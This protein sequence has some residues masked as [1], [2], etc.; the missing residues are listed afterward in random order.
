MAGDN[1]QEVPVKVYKSKERLTVA[2]PMPGLEPQDIQVWL[3]EQ[4]ELTLEG[5]LRGV[6][7]GENEVLQDEWNAGDYHRMLRLED[8]V[9]GSRGNATYNNGVL[10]V[11]LPLSASFSPGRLTLERLTPTQGRLAVTAG[12]HLLPADQNA[13]RTHTP[14]AH[15]GGRTSMPTH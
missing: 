13:L 3:D 15:T 4:G 9:D 12:R 6:L 8:S 7:K 10:V 5:Q 1:Q 14:G 11:S 2:A